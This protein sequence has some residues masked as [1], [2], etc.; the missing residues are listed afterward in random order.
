MGWKGKCK[1]IEVPL[2]TNSHPMSGTPHRSPT[3][4]GFTP[5]SPTLG[6]KA[7]PNKGDSVPKGN[8]T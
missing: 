2:L 4:S 6:S 5:G 7:L 1:E 8:R 3:K